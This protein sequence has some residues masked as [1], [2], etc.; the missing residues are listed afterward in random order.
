M[1]PRDSATY[2]WII[3]KD[4]LAE[5][6]NDDSSSVGVVGPSDAPDELVERLNK[7]EGQ[8]FKMYDDDGELYFTGKALAINGEEDSEEYLFGPLNDFGTPDSGAVDIHWKIN[9][10]W[11]SV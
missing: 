5:T 10:K 2:A 6:F 4:H 3:T 1:N 8:L 11:E 9:G 7:G